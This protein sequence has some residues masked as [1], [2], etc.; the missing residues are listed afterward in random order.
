MSRRPKE[1]KIVAEL[2]RPE[3]PEEAAARKAENSRLYRERKTVNNLVLSMLVVVGVVLV[4]FFAVPRAEN[5][6]NWQVD[7]VALSKDAEVAMGQK[8]LVP[9][10]PPSWKAN[11][12]ELRNIKTDAVTSWYIGFITPTNGYIGYEEAFGANPT[13]VKNL[14]KKLPSTGSR[15]IDGRTWTEYNNRSTEGAGNAAYALATTAGNRTIVLYGTA[16]NAEFEALATSVS[17]D[18]SRS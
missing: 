16:S 4:I 6:P 9:A 15:V 13:W 10:M 18:L 2:G 1:P 11:A 8:L 7:Y 3:T 12:A 14:L 5:T 17:A